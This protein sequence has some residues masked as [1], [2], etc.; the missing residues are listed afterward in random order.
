VAVWSM[1]RTVLDH[2]NTGTV[3]SQIPSEL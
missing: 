2:T 3:G 1:A